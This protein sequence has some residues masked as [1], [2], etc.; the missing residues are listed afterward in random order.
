MNAG[1]L[2]SLGGGRFRGMRT[3]GGFVCA[4]MLRL[5]ALAVCKWKAFS[6]WCL[7]FTI[8]INGQYS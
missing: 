7:R 2:R 4:K 6:G 8:R 5:L 1:V 3:T